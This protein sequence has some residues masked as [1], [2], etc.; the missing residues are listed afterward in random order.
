MTYLEKLREWNKD[1]IENHGLIDIK[2]FPSVFEIQ[3]GI[4]APC[5]VSLEEL[6]KEVYE[7]LTGKTIDVTDEVL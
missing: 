7:M 2:F 6:A 5:S 4:C 3:A 1:Q